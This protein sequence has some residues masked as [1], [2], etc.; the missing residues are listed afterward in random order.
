VLVRKLADFAAPAATG[1]ISVAST[2][3]KNEFDGVREK[4]ELV[5]GQSRSWRLTNLIGV[6][7]GSE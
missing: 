5:R 6:S 2:T 4:S 3:R 1:T 7:E